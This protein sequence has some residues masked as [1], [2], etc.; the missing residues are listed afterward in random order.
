MLKSTRVEGRSGVA[1]LHADDGARAALEGWIRR[2]GTLEAAAAAD[3]GAEILQGR[4]EV[5]VV[6][7]P[8]GDGRWVVRHYHRG[9]AVAGLL[10]DR[11][12]RAG[13]P[14]PVRELRVGRRIRDLGVP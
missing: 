10:G 4:G 13:T 7:A 12:L 8:D 14:R 6:P 1:Q 2:H 5:M 9:G 3:P 11:Y